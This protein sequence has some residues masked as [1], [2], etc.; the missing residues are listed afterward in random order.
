[1]RFLH[2]VAHGDV[3]L[4]LHGFH[5]DIMRFVIFLRFQRRQGHA[6]AGK[7]AFTHGADDVS[8]D[9][10]DIESTFE[11]IAA[12]VAVEHALPRK[13][14]RNRNAKRFAERFEQADIRQTPARLPFGNRLVA[15]LQKLRELLLRIS[16]FLTERFYRGSGDIVRHVES[17]YFFL[18][19]GAYHLCFLPATYAP[20]SCFR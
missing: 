18:M 14:F 20:W 2:R 12:A 7:R 15:D 6:A 9:R 10:A 13:Q 19:K 3:A 16:F 1:M 8:A 11:H 5:V 4:V 17:S